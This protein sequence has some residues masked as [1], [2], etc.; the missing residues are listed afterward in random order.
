MIFL[1]CLITNGH[2]APVESAGSLSKVAVGSPMYDVYCNVFNQDL[3]R[4]I[5][6]QISILS[7]GKVLIYRI[8]PWKAQSWGNLDCPIPWKKTQLSFAALSSNIRLNHTKSTFHLKALWSNLIPREWLNEIQFYVWVTWQ[9][10][11]PRQETL[12]GD[13]VILKDGRVYFY[14]SYKQGFY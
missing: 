3:A 7:H 12:K 4:C 1:S 10:L 13:S 14:Y 8:F 6:R 5:Q 2:C 11:F 9:G